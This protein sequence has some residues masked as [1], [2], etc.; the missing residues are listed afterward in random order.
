ML[1]AQVHHARQ[2]DN[3][4]VHAE[5]GVGN[6]QLGSAG[7]RFLQPLLQII[8]VVVL[9][10]QELGARHHA[11]IHNA[12][13]V[14]LVRE[15]VIM[16]SHQRG[17]HRKIGHITRRISYRGF[18][19]LEIG[20][21]LLEFRMQFQRAGQAAHAVRPGAVLVDGVFGGLVDARMAD[22]S[23]VTVGGKHA[24]FAA[25]HQHSSAAAQL[26]DGLVVII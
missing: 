12:G 10:T 7:R 5:H 4:A 22:Q 17:D 9:E 16:A 6:H 11:P 13:V 23:E 2:I 20:D 15:H 1:S 24:H 26:C 8:Q 14:E 21:G 19:M 25:A 18:G 3:V